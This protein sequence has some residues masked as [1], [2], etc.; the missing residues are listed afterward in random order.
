MEMHFAFQK[1]AVACVLGKA[2]RLHYTLKFIIHYLYEIRHE[3]YDT[4]L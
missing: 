3:V 2:L 4:S 1:Y